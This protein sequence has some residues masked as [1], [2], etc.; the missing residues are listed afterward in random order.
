VTDV[1]ADAEVRYRAAKSRRAGME[2]AWK[3][4][5]SLLLGKGSKGET[6]E[7]R[8]VKMLREHDLLLD[9]LAAPLRKTHGARS[10]RL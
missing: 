4:E 6:T 7:H 10:R 9:R 1:L 8:L 5:G 3:T 2:R